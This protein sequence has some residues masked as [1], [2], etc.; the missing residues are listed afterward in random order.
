MTTIAGPFRKPVGV[1][2]AFLTIAVAGCGPAA[3]K[4]DPT[5]TIQA[6]LASSKALDSVL[7]RSCGDCHSNTPSGHWATRVAPFSWIMGRAAKDGRKV[8]NFDEWST[9]TPEQQRAF[10]IGSCTDAKSGTMPVG[11]YVRFRGE[12]RLSARDVETICAA[13]TTTSASASPTPHTH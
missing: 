3:I 4:T 9:Y 6:Q 13:S 10:L 1:A 8:L 2:A 7:V 5:H 12:A 11:S